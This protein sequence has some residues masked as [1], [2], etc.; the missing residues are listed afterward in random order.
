MQA[1]PAGILKK[2]QGKRERI[3]NLQAWWE[4]GKI[5]RGTSG[6]LVMEDWGHFFRLARREEVV[7]RAPRPTSNDG[8]R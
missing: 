7:E 8:K 6:N 1:G 4:R 3:R 2:N 5:L